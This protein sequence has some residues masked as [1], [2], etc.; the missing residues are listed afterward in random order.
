MK[1]VWI[2]TDIGT[3]PDDATAIMFAAKHPEIDL[4]GLSIS[5][6]K[7]DLR[8]K[9]AYALLD[10]LDLDIEVHLGDYLESRHIENAGVENLVAIGPLTNIAKL[11]L[12][13]CQINQLHI[14]N[15]TFAPIQYR[16]ELTTTETNSISDKEAT[17][18]V[19]TQHENISISALDASHR[20]ILEGSRLEQIGNRHAF[21]K[22]RYEGYVDYLTKKFG[23]NNQIILN[24]VLPICDILNLVSIQREVMEFYIQPDGSF[25]V[26]SDASSR[27]A[28]AKVEDNPENL[29]VPLVK[30]QVIFN[31]N[32]SKVIDELLKVL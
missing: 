1:K 19:L 5:G 32:P 16:G 14:M 6:T 17:R 29:P 21:L 13:D 11:I 25:R 4:V 18:I 8:I 3:N 23:D 26:H 9:E 22:N 2:D 15:G 24:D 31:V 7:Q 20:I 28:I 12:D 27:Q 30:H 10:Y